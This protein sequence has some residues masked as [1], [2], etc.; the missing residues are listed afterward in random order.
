[1]DERRARIQFEQF[2]DVIAFA[3][4]SSGIHDR[5]SLASIPFWQRM[6]GG[7]SERVS[8]LL[9]ASAPDPQWCGSLSTA[10]AALQACTAV[11][12][13]EFMTYY[14]NECSNRIQGNVT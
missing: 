1:M 3:L 8:R 6:Y 10:H 7:Y 2:G 11:D 13:A 9:L 5:Q 12:F 14:F 4:R